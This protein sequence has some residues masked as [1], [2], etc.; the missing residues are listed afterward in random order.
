MWSKEMWVTI[1]T[2]GE[3]KTLVAS[4]RPPI[5][6]S[7]TATSTFFFAKYCNAQ[8]V[9]ISNDDAP[10]LLSLLIFRTDFSMSKN[11]SLGMTVLLIVIQSHRSIRCGE[12][13]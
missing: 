11:A 2:R 10:I 9:S 5:P 3:E 13:N 4:V 7:M 12:L 6:V 8:A 1:V